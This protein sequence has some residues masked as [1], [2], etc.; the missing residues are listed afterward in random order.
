MF[1]IFCV[2]RGLRHRLNW[3]YH[4][5]IIAE[6]SKLKS[7][8][9]LNRQLTP[10][11]TASYHRH[12]LRLPLAQ[13]LDILIPLFL[14]L[15]LCLLYDVPLPQPHLPCIKPIRLQIRPEPRI[16]QRDR[17]LPNLR[18]PHQHQHRAQHAQAPRHPKRVLRRQRLRIAPGSNNIRKHPGPHKRA[19]LAHRRRD[20]IV[21]PAHPGGA[22]LGREQADVVAGAELAQREEDAVDGGEG[23]DHLRAREARVAAGHDEPHDGLQQHADGEGAARAEP[24]R[25]RRAEHGAGDVEQVDDGVPAKDGGQR[26]G[27][28]VEDVGEDGGRVDA[29]GVGGEVVDEPDEADGEE[30]EA[31]EFEHERVGGAGVLE[32]VLLEFFGLA[33]EEAHDEEDGGEDGPDGKAYTPDGAEVGVVACGGHDVGDEGAEDEALG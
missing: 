32:G 10:S 4:Y 18:Q 13:P 25:Q 5:R 27:G 11:S 8:V 24:V 20:T 15:L 16:L 28:R 29:E 1:L 21:L 22:R 30:A 14:S 17:I 7:K 3:Y 9:S 19:N 12:I 31:V 2:E 23:A 33:D 6:F 26:G